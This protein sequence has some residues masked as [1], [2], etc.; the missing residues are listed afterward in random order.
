[1]YLPSL[2]CSE[3]V[4]EVVDESGMQQLAVTNS[5]QKLRT[6]RDGVPIDLP[7]KVDWEHTL[8]PGFQQ[9]KVIQ[10]M[11]EAHDHPGETL[12]HLKHEDEE[13]PGLSHEEHETHRLQL[14]QQVFRVASPAALLPASPDSSWPQPASLHR[15][16]LRLR[17]HSH[18]VSLARMSPACRHVPPG[19]P[20]PQA[21]L[22]QGR[23]AQLTEAA[24]VQGDEQ[25]NPE[26]QRMHLEVTAQ[27]LN[28]M[29][30]EIAQTRIYSATQREQ[31]LSNLHSMLRNVER[32]QN[33]SSTTTA[34]NLKEALRIRLSI[35]NDNVQ[36]FRLGGGHRQER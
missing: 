15:S 22:L 8:A 34:S 20:N 1:M 13:N 17:C 18:L 26:A 31:V 24:E 32:L 29:R 6:D 7:Q 16:L 33:G 30:E 23:L 19:P 10:M 35:L 2:P 14:S 3:I 5:L 28:R 27:E 11:E 25:N 12:M 9:R 21:A 36:G 4:L